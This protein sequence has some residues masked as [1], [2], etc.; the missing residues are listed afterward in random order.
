M[1]LAPEEDRR[2]DGLIPVEADGGVTEDPGL[3]LILKYRGTYCF[4][5]PR[6]ERSPGPDVTP[7]S[8]E[9]MPESDNE[10]R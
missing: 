4:G 8:L 7:K 2:A 3:E 9:A 6:D 1:E 10:P 5:R